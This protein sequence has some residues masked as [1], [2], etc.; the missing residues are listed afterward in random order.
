MSK[1]NKKVTV[2]CP[3]C[4]V[5]FNS[6]KLKE[7]IDNHQNLSED[8]EVKIR[9]A[10]AVSNIEISSKIRK[11]NG[12][13]IYGATDAMNN[14]KQFYHGNVTLLGGAFGQGKKR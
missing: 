3:I 14:K 6:R 12:S 5:T 13:N 11:E 1:I 10:V 2:L 8:A 9:K 7:H 4:R